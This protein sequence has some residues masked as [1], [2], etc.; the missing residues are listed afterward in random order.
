[1]AAHTTTWAVNDAFLRV[2]SWNT[3]LLIWPSLQAIYQKLLLVLF[4]ISHQRAAELQSKAAGEQGILLTRQTFDVFWLDSGGGD[5]QRLREINVLLIKR[6]WVGGRQTVLFMTGPVSALSRAPQIPQTGKY[7]NCKQPRLDSLRGPP[8]RLF[9]L[10]LTH[11]VSHTARNVCAL[12]QNHSKTQ[13]TSQSFTHTPFWYLH[14][15][16]WTPAAA[17]WIPIINPRLHQASCSEKRWI[18]RVCVQFVR[19]RS[20]LIVFI[21]LLE[22]LCCIIKR[23]QKTEAE[24]WLLNFRTIKTNLEV[25]LTNYLKRIFTRIKQNNLYPSIMF[26]H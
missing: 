21:N 17:Q 3:T 7:Y 13:M 14:P 15:P 24:K 8:V 19:L 16:A 22:I 5:Y 2:L 6:T 23:Q 4:L 26:L 10:L 25:H 1:M 12:I 9:H 20:Q 18:T 11:L